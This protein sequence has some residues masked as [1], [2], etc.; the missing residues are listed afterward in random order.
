MILSPARA[1]A[2]AA[3]LTGGPVAANDGFGGLAATG[4]TFGRTDAVA[5]VDE[6]LFIGPDRIRVDYVFRNLTDQDV[7][8]EV[9]F[10]LPP[11]GVWSLWEQMM[12]LPEGPPYPENLLNFT[13]TVDG[14]PVT[15]RI[16]RIA[17]I[18]PEWEEN[19]PLN[20]QYDTPGRDVTAELERYGLPLD[21]DPQAA[22]D[23]L[24]ALSPADRAA[25]TEAG[26]AQYFE[27]DTQNQIPEQAFPTWSVVLRYHWTQTFPAGAELRVHHEYDHRPPGGIFY[28]THPVTNETDW[29]QTYVDQF[30]IDDGTSAAMARAL[31]RKD[32]SSDEVYNYGTAFF[33]TYVLRTANSWAGPIGH[34]RLTLDKGD[35]ANVISLCAEGVKKTG[36]TTFVVEKTDYTPDR[37][38]EILLVVPISD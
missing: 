18:E 15:P 9:I 31:E 1:L 16:D 6:D 2:L 13:V 4:L 38:L 11:I 14:Q 29:L 21:L 22:M 24:L 23:R 10:P 35:A 20:E 5:M 33:M 34:F 27:A 30:C 28:W 12:N 37:D 19:H 26:L 17:V 25:V 36:P 8:G 7:T 3:L 32:P